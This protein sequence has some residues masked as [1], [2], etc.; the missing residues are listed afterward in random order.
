M[1]QVIR[2]GKPYGQLHTVIPLRMHLY[3]QALAFA[4]AISLRKL[5]ANACGKFLEDRPWE[6][7]LAWR[8]S[9]QITDVN[10]WEWTAIAVVLPP[11]MGQTVDQLP[12]QYPVSAASVLYT[13]LFWYSW[14]VFPPLHEQIRRKEAEDFRVCQNSS[15]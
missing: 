3:C 9:P 12:A 11:D 13:M 15:R 14:V 10:D 6:Q 2:N 5:H 1:E 7:G 4:Q 8:N